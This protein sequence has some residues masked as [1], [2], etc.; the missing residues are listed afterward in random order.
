MP[1]IVLFLARM[2]VVTARFMWKHT[3]YAIL[4]IFIVAAVV[5]PSGDMFTQTAM[6]TPMIGLYLFSIL[7]AWIFGKKKKAADEE[8]ADV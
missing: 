3:K 4:I 8:P 1:T 2:G 5:T 7:L 6:A